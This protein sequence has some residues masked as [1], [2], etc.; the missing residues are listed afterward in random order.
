MKN[1][2]EDPVKIFFWIYFLLT[3]CKRSHE[4]LHKR[5]SWDLILL[6]I[7]KRENSDEE[8]HKFI[9]FLRRFFP[10]G[11]SFLAPIALPFHLAFHNFFG[12]MR[13]GF[14]LLQ[15]SGKWHDPE[16][17]YLKFTH[18][19]AKWLEVTWECNFLVEGQK[20]WFFISKR[21]AQRL[22]QL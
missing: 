8:L 11:N 20:C 4:D 7:F 15:L 14:F 21:H 19:Y 9:F 18:N 2:K 5:S 17:L 16:K 1:P 3:I 12:K 6:K 13:E 22:V 10:L